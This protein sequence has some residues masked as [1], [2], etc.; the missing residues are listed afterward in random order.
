MNKVKYTVVVYKKRWWSWRPAI[1]VQPGEYKWMDALVIAST[2]A[3]DKDVSLVLIVIKVMKFVNV[4]AAQRALRG[5]YGGDDATG[6]LV[7]SKVYQVPAR[8]NDREVIRGSTQPC[9]KTR[10]DMQ[11][12]PGDLPRDKEEVRGDNG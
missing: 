2:L 9:S 4:A 11:E 7:D 12:R 1:H 10:E 6:P 8:S 3:S 5:I